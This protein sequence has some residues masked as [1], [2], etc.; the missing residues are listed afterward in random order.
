MIIETKFLNK[1]KEFGLNS[2][3]AKIWTALLSRGVSSAGELSD[4]SNFFRVLGSYPRHQ[5]D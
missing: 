1:L 3:E 4:I 5:I 2:Y